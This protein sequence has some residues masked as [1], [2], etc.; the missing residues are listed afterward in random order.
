MHTNYPKYHTSVL[1]CILNF[2]IKKG[3]KFGKKKPARTFIKSQARKD[4]SDLLFV[5]AQYTNNP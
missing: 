3:T 5:F 2:V 4:I 1:I